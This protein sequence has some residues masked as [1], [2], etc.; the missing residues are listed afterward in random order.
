[1]NTA[2]TPRLA[3]KGIG[4]AFGGVPVLSNVDFTVEAGKVV[5]LL[6]SNGAGKSTLMKILT[7]IYPRDGGTIAID[8]E[9][10]SFAAPA[11]A[12]A[13]GVRLLPQ[14]IS[15]MPDMTVAE[16]IFVGDLPM[17]KGPFGIRAVDDRAMK[18]RSREL[19][20]QLG[21]GSIDPEATM[22]RLSVA[23]QR[24]V[25]I[26]RALAGHARILIMDEPTAALTEQEAELIF[27]I[28]RRLKE[29]SVSVVYI[30]HYLSEVFAISDS[31][32]VLRDGRNA[33]TFLTAATSQADVL[34]AMLGNTVDDLYA[35]G[36]AG[37][38]GA[39]VLSVEALS[40]PG[41]IDDVGFS[42]RAGE[43]LGIFG[44]VGS[45]IEV[46]GRALYGALGQ[47]KS[48]TVRLGGRSY[49][50][51]SPRAGKLAGIGFVAAE[52]K[53]E[54][55]IAELTVRENIALSFEERFER[56]LFVSQAAETANAV[57]WIEALGI[58]ARS[59]EQRLRT[60]S[61]GNQQK[62]CIARWLVDGVQLLILE[63]PTRGVDVGARKE[64]YA[65][66]RELADRGFAVL[67]LSSDV[68]EV[69]GLGD[70]MLV[71]DRGRVVGRFERG[72]TAAALMAATNDDPAF[73]AA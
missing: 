12:I 62:V 64:I 36:P 39:D 15:V 68:E 40:I 44:L 7:G 57:K 50:P 4:K 45:G 54:G 73:S 67:V 65:K 16:N 10:V 23:E 55:I 43:I 19:L 41:K 2:A 58:R 6:G 27:R 53:K 14:E 21:F 61:G 20:D 32:V 11:E 63:E 59:P 13:A 25:E 3:M 30:S 9:P 22:K 47:L 72:A 71:L 5:A 1:M 52:R 48:G 51:S 38:P 69:A 8:G 34:S 42:I 26:A 66:L 35:T 17:R 37:A 56:G 70:R 18:A 33:G 49:R 29:Q 46:L 24:I 60:L 31:I 28:I